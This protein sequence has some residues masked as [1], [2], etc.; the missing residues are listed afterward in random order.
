MK[1][2]EI[3][4]AKLSE[5]F[6]TLKGAPLQPWNA[7][8]FDAWACEQWGSGVQHAARFVLAVW[9]VDATWRVGRFDAMSA[10]TAWDEAHRKAFA[11][12]C[13]SAWWR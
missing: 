6:P 10:L 11:Q 4:I 2:Y 12:W 5:T 7:D 9:A 8:A 3:E 13:L 1:N